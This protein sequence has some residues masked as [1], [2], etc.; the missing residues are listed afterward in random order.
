MSS[1]SF[2]QGRGGGH[3]L[4]PRDVN[5]TVTVVRQRVN[6]SF[7]LLTTSHHTALEFEEARQPG[8]IVADNEFGVSAY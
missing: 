6:F 2:L 4:G 7:I 3:L 1:G 5:R 8:F